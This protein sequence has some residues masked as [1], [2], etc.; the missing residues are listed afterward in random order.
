MKNTIVQEPDQRGQKKL[1]NRPFYS[2]TLQGNVQVS[3]LNVFPSFFAVVCW[4]NI[5]TEEE[6]FKHRCDQELAQVLQQ[7]QRQTEAEIEGIEAKATSIHHRNVWREFGQ[8]FG[9]HVARTWL[10]ALFLP[11]PPAERQEPGDVLDPNFTR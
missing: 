5:L 4:L 8:H 3:H 9:R 7:R 6:G 2:R 1:Q 11:H 10:S